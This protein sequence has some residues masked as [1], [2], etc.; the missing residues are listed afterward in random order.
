MSISSELKLISDMAL[1]LSQL[2]AYPLDAEKLDVAMLACADFLRKVDSVKRSLT[3][4]ITTDPVVLESVKP[5][6]IPWMEMP[7]RF[8]WSF[9][10]EDLEN[11][12]VTSTFGQ[13]LDLW[14]SDPMGKRSE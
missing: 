5:E 2:T 14:V 8:A 10:K 4:F 12:E 1:G 3:D 7:Y 9:R 6:G 11:W 13:V